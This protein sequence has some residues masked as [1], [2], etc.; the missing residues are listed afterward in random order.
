MI[1]EINC[2]ETTIP[3]VHFIKYSAK[4]WP[5]ENCNSAIGCLKDCLRKRDKRVDILVTK[6]FTKRQMEV[7]HFG[8]RSWVYCKL[9]TSTQIGY[10]ANFLGMSL[11]PRLGLLQPFYKNWGSRSEWSLNWAQKIFQ[12]SCCSAAEKEMIIVKSFWISF[13]V[14]KNCLKPVLD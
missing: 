8:E 13:K 7:P 6:N 12:H 5:N 4:F 11:L 3:A 1:F 9:V 14:L 10:A 2:L